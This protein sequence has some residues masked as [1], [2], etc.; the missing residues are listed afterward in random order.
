MIPRP[1]SKTKKRAMSW[2]FLTCAVACVLLVGNEIRQSSP[3]LQSDSSILGVPLDTVLLDH[4]RGLSLASTVPTNDDVN[5]FENPIRTVASSEDITIQLPPPV[6]GKHRSDVDAIFGFA[7]GLPKEG[8][9]RFVGTLVEAKYA[10]DI[11]LALGRDVL[12]DTSQEGIAFRE[13]LAYYGQNHNLVIHVIHLECTARSEKRS[14]DLC[15]APYVFWNQKTKSYL[16]DPRVPR[17]VTQ[18]R[19]EYY[20]AWS[21]Y[22]SSNSRILVSDVRDVYFQL[23]PFSALPDDKNMERTMQVFVEDTDKFVVKTQRANS[24]WI[25]ETRGEDE[26]QRVGDNPIVCSGTTVGGQV[27]MVRCF[28]VSKVR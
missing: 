24:G 8:I 19:F 7:K 11:V 12:D 2:Q 20:W 13:Y 16:P 1:P 14:E 18:M 9:V 5:N 27:A 6:F 21:R 28:D 17:H 25:R 15:Q 10:G 3:S 23:D 26:L 4:S 22:Y